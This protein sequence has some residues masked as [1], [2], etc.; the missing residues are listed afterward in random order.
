M[1]FAKH[2]SNNIKELVA[3]VLNAVCSHAEL[4]GYVVQQGGSKALVGLALDGTE[5]G[6]RKAAQALSRIGISQDPSIA[7]PGQRVCNIGTHIAVRAKKNSWNQINQFHEII[8]GQ[9]P[10]YAISKMA[11][12]QFLNWEKV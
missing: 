1:P 10:F 9:I 5:K 12:N 7:F 6:K 4:R 8:F 3:R 2:D 11:K